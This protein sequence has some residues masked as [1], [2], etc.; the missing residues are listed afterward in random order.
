MS[1]WN[2]RALRGSMGSLLRLPVISGADAATVRRELDGLGFRHVCASTRGGQ[3]PDQVDWSGPMAL[4]VSGETGDTPAAMRDLPGI[5]IPLA[6]EVESLNVTVASS[7]LL[8][9]AGRV[10]QRGLG[11]QRA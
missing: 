11:G 1:P 4:W 10:R 7:L 8:F 3:T 5:T 2:A 9:A 6:G